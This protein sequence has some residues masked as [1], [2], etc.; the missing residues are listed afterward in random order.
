MGFSEAVEQEAENQDLPTLK[1]R[2]DLRDIPFVTIDPADARD[3][4]DAV[5]AQP[6][7]DP[8]NAGGWIVWVAIADVAAYVRPGTGAG[9][10]GPRQGQHHLLPR[11]RRA[12]AARAAV[13]R[14]VQPEGGRE[15][16]HAWPCAWCSTRTAARPATSSF[17]A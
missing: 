6:D 7:D 9:P 3:H 1:G 5:Y 8:K 4:D 17:A 15:P 12:D 16:R 13:E 2:D 14:P 11:P 10:R